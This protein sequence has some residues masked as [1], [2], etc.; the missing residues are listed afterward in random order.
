MAAALAGT[1]DVPCVCASGDDKVCAEFEAKIPACETVTVKWGLA[2]QNARSL[3]PAAARE[4]IHAGV[5]RGLERRA[6][7]PPYKI[8]GPYRLN[9]SDRNPEE[10][11][12]PEDVAGADLWE[13]FHRAVNSMPYG[14]F[15]EDALDDRSY[16]WPE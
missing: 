6:D 12:F 8:P 10:K 16:R 13:T 15:G 2:A 9:L 4:R 5:C 7:I 14:H 11:A 3:M 1:F